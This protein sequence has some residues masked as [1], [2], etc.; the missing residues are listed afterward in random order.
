MIYLEFLAFE[1]LAQEKLTIAVC[2]N[3]LLRIK[4]VWG[5]LPPTLSAASYNSAF[6]EIGEV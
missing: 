1:S 6:T 5:A 4:Q 3:I 2:M